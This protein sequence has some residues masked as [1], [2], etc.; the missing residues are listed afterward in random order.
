MEGQVKIYL[1]IDAPLEGAALLFEVTL[2]AARASQ[3]AEHIEGLVAELP[4]TEDHRGPVPAA[5]TPGQWPK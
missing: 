2:D 1:V 3:A 4:V 5:W